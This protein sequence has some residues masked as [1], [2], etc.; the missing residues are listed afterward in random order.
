M[1]PQ[2]GTVRSD[3]EDGLPRF[4]D[5]AQVLVGFDSHPSIDSR[6]EFFRAHGTAYLVMDYE[7]GRSPA[8]VLASREAEGCPFIES[9]LLAVMMLQARNA[10]SRPNPTHIGFDQKGISSSAS[11]DLPRLSGTSFIR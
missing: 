2:S 11:E 7:D 4:R 5:E 10:L 9:E 6:R 8:E 3:F 1:R